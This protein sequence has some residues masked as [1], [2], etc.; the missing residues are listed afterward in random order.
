MSETVY[1]NLKNKLDQENLFK[2]TDIENNT[3]KY[4]IFLIDPSQS[5]ITFKDINLTE[6]ELEV[7]IQNFEKFNLDN[8][9]NINVNYFEIK[10]C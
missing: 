3:T 4:I 8:I 5:V 7:S 6:H 1:Q 9:L 10:F 2:L